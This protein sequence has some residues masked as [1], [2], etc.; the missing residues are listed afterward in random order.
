VLITG[1]VLSTVCDIMQRAV[2]DI[3]E[4]CTRHQLA[5]IMGGVY[6]GQDNFYCRFL[7]RNKDNKN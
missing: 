4:L 3:D 6:Q 2:K 7:Q 1:I 5:V